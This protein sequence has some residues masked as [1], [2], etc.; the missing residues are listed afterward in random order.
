MVTSGPSFPSLRHDAGATCGTPTA[1]GK[2]P[3]SS[4]ARAPAAPAPPTRRQQQQRWQHLHAQ[5]QAPQQPRGGPQAQLL[6]G[7]Q[8]R[9]EEGARVRQRVAAGAARAW[10]ASRAGQPGRCGR[11]RRTAG[12]GSAPSSRGCR[13]WLPAGAGGS[14]C[15]STCNLRAPWSARESHTPLSH[16]V[17]RRVTPRSPP[18]QAHLD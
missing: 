15:G 5:A 1:P 9:E 16:T 6:P 12:Q 18:S 4:P 3:P 8:R 14:C 7:S 11:P 10:R 2:A 17:T 13:P